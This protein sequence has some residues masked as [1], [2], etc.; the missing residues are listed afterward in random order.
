M[1]VF[2]LMRTFTQFLEHK[3]PPPL[4]RWRSVTSK[5][6]LQKRIDLANIDHCGPCGHQDVPPIINNKK[7][8]IDSGHFEE[9]K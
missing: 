3:P 7:Y 2:R 9:S 1:S 4:G 6:A 5:D 8:D